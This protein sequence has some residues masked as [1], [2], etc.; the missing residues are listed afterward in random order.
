M[1]KKIKLE[2]KIMRHIFKYD[3]FASLRKAMRMPVGIL[4][5][6]KVLLSFLKPE[7]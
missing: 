4:L 1:P 2:L 6:A 7:K 5:L 3:K